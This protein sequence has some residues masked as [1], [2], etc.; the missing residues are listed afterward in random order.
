MTS[1]GVLR[2][3]VYFGA[4]F[5]CSWLFTGCLVCVG[6]WVAVVYGDLLRLFG[7]VCCV[8]RVCSSGVACLI[9]CLWLLFVALGLVACCFVDDWLIVVFAG[10]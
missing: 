5:D 9:W 2:F 6:G 4:V 7:F 8:L 10:W 3:M 1:G